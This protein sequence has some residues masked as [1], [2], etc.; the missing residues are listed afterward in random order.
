M[1]L[2]HHFV[3]RIEEDGSAEIDWD[4]SLNFDSGDVWDTEK[5]EWYNRTEE[6]VSYSYDLAEARLT[7]LLKQTEREIAQ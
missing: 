4:T 1:A 7:A 3:V 6:A 2:Q 5:E